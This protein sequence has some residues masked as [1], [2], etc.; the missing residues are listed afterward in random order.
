MKQSYYVVL[1][2]ALLGAVSQAIKEGDP[3]SL[4]LTLYVNGQEVTQAPSRFLLNNDM[5]SDKVYTTLCQMAQS[6]IQEAINNGYLSTTCPLD[7]CQT[8]FDLHLK[9]FAQFMFT[10]PKSL[11]CENYSGEIYMR[12]KDVYKVH[13]GE[14]RNI[15]NEPQ[16]KIFCSSNY[17]LD[18]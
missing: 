4:G 7:Y 15:P 8:K 18:M 17:A 6:H 9:H 10:Q 3:F 16:M 11:F 1:T 12:S 5:N 13:L 2:W 14:H